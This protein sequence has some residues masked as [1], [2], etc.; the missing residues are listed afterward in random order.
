MPLNFNYLSNDF[1]CYIKRERV[2]EKERNIKHFKTV[3]NKLIMF[4]FKEIV[5]RRGSETDVPKLY[6]TYN[7]YELSVL[8]NY[9]KNL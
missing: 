4:N 2:R 8:Y 5:H 1:L 6:L 9:Q 3:L 7:E